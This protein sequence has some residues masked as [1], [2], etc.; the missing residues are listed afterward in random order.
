M[1]SFNDIKALEQQVLFLDRNRISQDKTRRA[2]L[3]QF[4]LGQR[5]LL[6][7]LDSQ[8]EYFDTQ[9]AY[10][11]AEADL[12]ISQAATLSNMGVLLNAM[13]VNGVNEEQLAELELDLSR[14]DGENSQGLCPPE[15]PTA[16]TL[17]KEALFAG[18]AATSDRYQAVGDNVL[19]LELLVTFALNSSVITSDFDGE[20]GNAAQFLKENPNVKATVEGH[21]DNTGT[22]EYN[23]W[24]SD[25]RAHA[26]RKMMI[27]DHGVD[28]SQISAIGVG[29]E[30][31]AV[32]NDT[33]EGRMANRR[34]ELILDG[35]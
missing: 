28:A 2:Y 1:I 26:V 17:D 27:E 18:L 34:V 24:L 29:Q 9:R 21:T 35:S 3:D 22:P 6:D 14:G 12:R 31:P 33:V 20:I 10:V 19:K 30:K 4:D 5:T 11:A 8:N 15:A 13:A 32:S 23:L 25:R 16:V 7:L